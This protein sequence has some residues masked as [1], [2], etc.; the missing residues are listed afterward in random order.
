MACWTHG[1]PETSHPS[2]E[3]RLVR[4]TV[5]LSCPDTKLRN[6]A[7]A[8]MT[9]AFPQVLQHAAFFPVVLS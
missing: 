3:P 4:D 5:S 9:L 8:V 2:P 1:H 6:G 7:C